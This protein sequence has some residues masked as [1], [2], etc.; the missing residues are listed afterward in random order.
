MKNQLGCDGR[1]WNRAQEHDELFQK[2]VSGMNR[3]LNGEANKI[4]ISVTC[5]GG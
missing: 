3:D 5:N 2:R 1:L 4:L